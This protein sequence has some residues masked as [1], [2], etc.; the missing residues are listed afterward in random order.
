MSSRSMITRDVSSKHATQVP[1][2]QNDDVVQTLAAQRSDQSLRER[3][4]PGADGADPLRRPR[5]CRM[6][7]DR[8]VDDSPTL[9]REQHEDERHASSERRDREE[10]H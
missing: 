8:Q 4:L 6:V 2:V 1:L 3:I 7:R 5:G 10:V 9:M